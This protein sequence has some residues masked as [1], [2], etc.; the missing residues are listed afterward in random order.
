MSADKPD[1]KLIKTKKLPK[2]SRTYWNT[3]GADKEF[4]P[5]E[6]RPES[7]P[8]TIVKTIKG[9][10]KTIVV[11]E[12]KDEW[13]INS[14]KDNYCFWSYIKRNSHSDGKMEPLL[15][16]EIA[17]LFG[18]SSTKVHFILKEALENL[19]GSVHLDDIGD[20]FEESQKDPEDLTNQSAMYNDV[21]ITDY[22]DSDS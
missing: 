19:L 1:L 11:K 8:Q 20:L 6:P 10:E 14:K 2:E 16:S 22:D 3:V 13:W 17:E 21:D 15:Q 4:Y 12:P 7:I 9:V 5:K 18:C